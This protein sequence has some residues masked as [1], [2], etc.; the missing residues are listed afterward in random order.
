MPWLEQSEPPSGT[1]GVD[2]S[3]C[4]AAAA[5]WSRAPVPG[6]RILCSYPNL[7][8]TKIVPDCKV[9]GRLLVSNSSGNRR[10]EPRPHWTS[11]VNSRHADTPK[12]VCVQ[13]KKQ[14]RS[15]STPIEQEIV[16]HSPPVNDSI[17]TCA[18]R[19]GIV[20]EGREELV[21][22]TGGATF[23]ICAHTLRLLFNRLSLLL[24]SR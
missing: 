16:R 14:D 23:R 18:R 13:P 4:D 9:D 19:H 8:Y 12:S 5:P 6:P 10:A 11:M 17:T 15:R 21:G 2:R 7:H 20:P 1:A 22:A 3:S 24:D